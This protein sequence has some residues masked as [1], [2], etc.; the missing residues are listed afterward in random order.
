MKG[1]NASVQQAL[2]VTMSK[3]VKVRYIDDVFFL[4]FFLRI[5][6]RKITFISLILTSSHC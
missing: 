5:E 4:L 6:R 1:L 3:I 2:K